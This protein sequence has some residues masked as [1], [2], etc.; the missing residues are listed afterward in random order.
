MRVEIP[1]TT[2]CCIDC[3]T[4]ELAARALSISLAECRFQEA[5][6]LTDRPMQVDGITVRQI[7]SIT[8]GAGYSIFVLTELARHIAT[9]FVLLIQWDGYVLSGAAWRPEFQAYD[10]VGAKWTHVPGVDV[11]NGG[12]SLRSRRLLEATA[13]PAFVVGHPE[14]E[15]VCVVNRP[16]LALG[17]CLRFAPPDLADRFAFER[18][19]HDGPHFGFHGLFNIPDIIA[20]DELQSFLAML[21]ARIAASTEFLEVVLRYYMSG[22]L[23]E[24]RRCWRRAL[25]LR[26]EAEMAAFLNEKIEPGEMGPKLIAELSRPD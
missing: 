3:S 19:R 18:Y 25:A 23:A 9:D 24:A 4:H 26:P 7:P 13:D 15:A 6:L 1:N 20:A 2:L 21:P 12:F 14:D 17:H 10:Y 11:G 8:S 5:L 22:R 16:L